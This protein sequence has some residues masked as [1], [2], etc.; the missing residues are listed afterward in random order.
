MSNVTRG[1]KLLRK[2]QFPSDLRRLFR[3]LARF[4][5]RVQ[6]DAPPLAQIDSL[7]AGL[8]QAMKFAAWMDLPDAGP[9]GTRARSIAV[10]TDVQRCTNRG[11]P[12]MLGLVL[13][14]RKNKGKLW[15]NHQVM[16]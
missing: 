1:P 12:A 11:K 5:E 9:M 14:S 15:E 10:L 8:T 2:P 6:S 16:A 4:V 3:E 13:T 7:D